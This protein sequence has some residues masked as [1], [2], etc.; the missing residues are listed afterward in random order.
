MPAILDSIFLKVVN[1]TSSPIKVEGGGWWGATKWRDLPIQKNSIWSN[2]VTIQAVF[3]ST[4]HK[5]QLHRCPVSAAMQSCGDSLLAVYLA[6]QVEAIYRPTEHPWTPDRPI[7]EA[8]VKVE[9]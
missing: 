2:G 4:Y 1:T 3:S 6:G 5:M 9:H 7:N 8:S